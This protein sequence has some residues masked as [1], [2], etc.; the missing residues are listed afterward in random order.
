MTQHSLHLNW[1][2]VLVVIP[3]LHSDTGVKEHPHSDT[4]MMEGLHSNTRVKEGME[5]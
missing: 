4:G 2:D 5:S 1:L 3:H